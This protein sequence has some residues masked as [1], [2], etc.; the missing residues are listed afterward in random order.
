[1][2]LLFLGWFFG[3]VKSFCEKGKGPTECLINEFF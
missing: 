2:V 1:M 3:G